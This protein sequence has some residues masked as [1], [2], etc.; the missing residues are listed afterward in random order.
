MFIYSET[1]KNDSSNKV[2]KSEDTIETKISPVS[3]KDQPATSA[4]RNEVKPL[5]INVI[6]GF[7]SKLDFYQ[8]DLLL[9]RVERTKK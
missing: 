3:N 9:N 4:D 7:T 2:E 8:S 1:K 5:I 6:I